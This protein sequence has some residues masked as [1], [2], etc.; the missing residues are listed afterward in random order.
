MTATFPSGTSHGPLV[1]QMVPHA[2]IC[3]PLIVLHTDCGCHTGPS[4]G[5]LPFLTVPHKYQYLSQWSFTWTMAYPN[6]PYWLF[7]LCFHMGH[8]L[9]SLAYDVHMLVVHSEII[10]L[11]NCSLSDL[12]CRVPFLL[13][14]ILFSS[15]FS[16]AY[17]SFKV[18]EMSLIVIKINFMAFFF[19]I[20]CVLSLLLGFILWY[21]DG[22]FAHVAYLK[23]VYSRPA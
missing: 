7:L 14:H 12:F 13:V 4:H 16:L 11:Y 22:F 6:S 1:F 19:F 3:H 17:F 2:D 8:A 21:S 18:Q 23:C 10:T 5:P 20:W 9:H 15:E